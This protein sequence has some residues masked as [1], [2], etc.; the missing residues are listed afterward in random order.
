MIRNLTLITL[1]S[2]VSLVA[3]GQAASTCVQT[4][5]LAQST[6]ESGRLH[7]LPSQLAGCLKSGFNDEERRQAY[8][9]LVQSYIYLEEPEKADEAMLAL[10]KTDHFFEPNDNVD[11]AEFVSLYNRYRTKPLF[12]IGA[13]L[14]PAMSAPFSTLDYSVGSASDGTATYTPSVTFFFGL[15]FEKDLIDRKETHRPV[16]T[17]VPELVFSTRGYKESS[18]VFMDVN[19]EKTAQFDGSIKLTWIEIN[20]LVKWWLTKGSSKV[21]PFVIGGPG[22][23]VSFKGSLDDAKLNHLEGAGTNTGPSIDISDVYKPV[24]LSAIAGV[25]FRYRLGSLYI[26]PDIRIQYGLTNIVDGHNRTNSEAATDYSWV[27]NDYRLSSITFNL[28]IQYAVFSP[29]KLIK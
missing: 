12:N 3:F 15:T 18:T 10:L 20:P 13:K 14:G 21:E 25:G 11:P 2:L 6:Y 24:N 29:K 1:L 22:V 16:L 5:R 4:L 17:I 7:E 27:P 9:L 8:K 26:V 19:N 23:N 28:G